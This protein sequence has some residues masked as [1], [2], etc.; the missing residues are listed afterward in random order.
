MAL[1]TDSRRNLR[2][3]SLTASTNSQRKFLRSKGDGICHWASFTSR[4]P[5]LPTV[6]TVMHT[7]MQTGL[8][9]HIVIITYVVEDVLPTCVKSIQPGRF[10]PAIW[11]A[12]IITTRRRLYYISRLIYLTFWQPQIISAV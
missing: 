5:H 10:N 12:D 1:L 2:R 7:F 3:W 6:T 4:Q 11:R 8:Q 9:L